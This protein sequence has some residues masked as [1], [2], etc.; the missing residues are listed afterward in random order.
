MSAYLKTLQGLLGK[1]ADA[2]KKPRTSPKK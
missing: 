2:E 1:H